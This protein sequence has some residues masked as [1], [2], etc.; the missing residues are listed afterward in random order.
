ME[1]FELYVKI[2]IESQLML[3]TNK[4]FDYESL[5][6]SI[7]KPKGRVLEESKIFFKN[8]FFDC[9]YGKPIEL[10]N[11]YG[12]CELFRTVLTNNGICYSFNSKKPSDY[13]KD[14]KIVKTL[15]NIANESYPI[16]KFKGPGTDAG[17]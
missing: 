8:L 9:R 10:D 3:N 7:L 13:Y 11:I 4:I 2:M 6:P 12:N 17:T 5:Y 14:G 16:V 15:E 1:N